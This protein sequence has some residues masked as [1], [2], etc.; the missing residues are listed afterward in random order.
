MPSLKEIVCDIEVDRRILKFLL[1]K[2][3]HISIISVYSAYIRRILSLCNENYSVSYRIRHDRIISGMPETGVIAYGKNVKQTRFTIYV[4]KTMKVMVV[5]RNSRIRQGPNKFGEI[6]CKCPYMILKNG[7]LQYQNL[8]PE[9]DMKPIKVDKY[10]I[11]E[12]N[13]CVTMLHDV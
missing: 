9:F 6:W 2:L 5:D 4:A 8:N 1:S 7:R 13:K 12:G 11:S 10:R 3:P